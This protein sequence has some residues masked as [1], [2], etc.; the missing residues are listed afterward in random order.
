MTV[1]RQLHLAVSLDGFGAHP[2]AWRR[3]ARAPESAFGS[4]DLHLD[5]ARRAEEGLLDFVTL[6]DS[7]PIHADRDGRARGRL[8]AALV[9][10]VVAAATDRIGLVP[11]GLTSRPVGELA[12]RIATLDHLSGGRA[13]WR[14]RVDTTPEQ[15]RLALAPDGGPLL[16]ERFAEAEEFTR[17]VL[18]FWDSWAPGALLADRADG[19][20]VD[21]ELIRPV[22]F[23]GTRVPASGSAAVPRPP[24][25]RPVTAILG[26]DT[27]PYRLLARHAEVAFITPF[28][29]AGLLAIRG[30]VERLR[31]EFGRSEQPYRLFA[32]LNVVLADTEAAARERL[33]DLDALD[34]EPFS[35]DAAVFAGTPVG[36]ADHLEEW[37][38][39]GGAD[40]FRLRP[41]VLA[42]DL[43][44]VVDGLIPE[45]RRRG[46]FRTAYTAQTLRGHLGLPAVDGPDP[47]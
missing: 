8:D 5:A 15:Q 44:A 24:Q 25:G 23:T 37:F 41:A 7:R 12:D 18:A 45:L 43:D 19:R 20:F 29:T 38:R 39:D 3:T 34:G 21:Q 27:V 22:D 16:V 1:G 6:D 9:L 46:L 32:D 42:E 28:D 13:G 4:A 40:G 11:T 2:A 10:A 26:H 33:A 17:A 35:S 14:P 31:K 30:E 47:R 36:L